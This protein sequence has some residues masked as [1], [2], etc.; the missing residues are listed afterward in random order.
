MNANRCARRTVRLVGLLLGLFLAAAAAA[1]ALV[2]TGPIP[3]PD[4]T[5]DCG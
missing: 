2:I 4:S 3:E 1:D 5:V